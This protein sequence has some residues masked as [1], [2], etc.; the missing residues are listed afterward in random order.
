MPNDYEKIRKRFRGVNIYEEIY[1]RAEK[2]MWDENSK[3]GYK[4]IRSSAH[5]VEFALEE[6]MKSNPVE[7]GQ[8]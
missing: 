5:L 4:K 3:S 2:F 6:Y 8:K 1:N 7:E